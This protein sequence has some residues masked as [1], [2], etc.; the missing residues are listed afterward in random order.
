MADDGQ[1]ILETI[2]TEF[3]KPVIEG[4]SLERTSFGRDRRQ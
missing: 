2:K 3:V 4:A 1:Y